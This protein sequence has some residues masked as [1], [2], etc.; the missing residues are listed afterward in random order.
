MLLNGATNAVKVNEQCQRPLQS[1]E[2]TVPDVSLHICTAA[3]FKD[4]SS[5]YAEDWEHVIAYVER[6]E[7]NVK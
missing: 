5:C 4:S 7:V 6:K 3:L 2:I 1:N